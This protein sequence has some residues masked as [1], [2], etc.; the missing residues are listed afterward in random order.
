MGLTVGEDFAD[1]VDQ[2]FYRVDVPWLLPF[3]H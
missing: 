3:H 1:V 2:S